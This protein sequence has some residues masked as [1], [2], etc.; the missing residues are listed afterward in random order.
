MEYNRIWKQYEFCYFLIN[1]MHQTYLSNM[2]WKFKYGVQHVCFLQ[3]RSHMIWK[4]RTLIMLITIV[5][6]R[7]VAF[8]IW[9]SV[10]NKLYARITY[11]IARS[12][13][14][15]WLVCSEP[16]F[17]NWA[18]RTWTNLPLVTKWMIQRKAIFHIFFKTKSL[19]TKYI[20][21]QDQWNDEPCKVYNFISSIFTQPQ[22]CY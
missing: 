19:L 5:W 20:L 8:I 3:T 18:W 1:M 9:K 15:H 14:P 11:F 16:P 12:W 13:C 17:F 7:T 10:L 6:S 22:M 2:E 21:L 4:I